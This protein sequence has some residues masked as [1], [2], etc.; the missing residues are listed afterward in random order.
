MTRR[1]EKIMEIYYILGMD[2]CV[3]L[4]SYMKT[5]IDK[6]D[7][8]IDILHEDALNKNLQKSPKNYRNQANNFNR[9]KY[10]YHNERR[11][12]KTYGQKQNNKRCR[13]A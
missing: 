4:E 12:Y 11:K 10:M 2:K 13:H 6:S 9:K 5:F 8:Y 7:Y 1:E 3:S